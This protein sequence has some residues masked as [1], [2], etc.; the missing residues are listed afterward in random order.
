MLSGINKI[1]PVSREPLQAFVKSNGKYHHREFLS[2]APAHIFSDI[3]R[4]DAPY[5]K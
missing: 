4:M 1:Q 2:N 5:L 3:S